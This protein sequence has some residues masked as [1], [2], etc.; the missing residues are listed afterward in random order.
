MATPK[1]L[2]LVSAQHTA[3]I[4]LSSLVVGIS[5]KAIGVFLISAFFVIPACAA[6]LL[7]RTFIQYILISAGFGALSAVIGMMVSAFFDLP[8]GPS[9]VNVQLVIF[10]L[11]MVTPNTRRLAL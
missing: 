4:V 9:I 5:I 11:A 7:S 8:S 6:R 2:M 3:F 1:E 10:L